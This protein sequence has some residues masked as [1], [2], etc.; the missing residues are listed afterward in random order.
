MFLLDPVTWLHGAWLGSAG[1]VG[2]G[3]HW[4][5]LGWAWVWAGAQ[6]SNTMTSTV[7]ARCTYVRTYVRRNIASLIWDRLGWA[8]LGWAGLGWS[9]LAGASG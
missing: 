6:E 8:G 4:A 7:L 2:L 9:G 3:L 1:W 5:G